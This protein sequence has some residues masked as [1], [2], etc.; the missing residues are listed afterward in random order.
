MDEATNVLVR[1]ERIQELERRRAPAA[2]LLE[3]L[4]ALV[5]EAEQWARVEGDARA[6]AAAADLDDAVHTGGEVVPL[7]QS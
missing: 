5:G 2:E 6:R 1:L 3:E 7:R 4:R